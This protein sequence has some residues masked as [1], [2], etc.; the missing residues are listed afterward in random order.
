MLE[1]LKQYDG[2]IFLLA[3]LGLFLRSWL[4]D[5]QFYRKNNWDYSKDSGRYIRPGGL[6]NSTPGMAPLSNE[7]KMRVGYPMLFATVS[8][9]VILSLFKNFL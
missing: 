2:P 7:K 4:L 9:F 5:I 3:I 8:I 1:F 6:F